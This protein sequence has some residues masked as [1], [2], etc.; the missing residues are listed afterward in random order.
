MIEE[1]ACV[2]KTLT[3]TFAQMVVLQAQRLSIDLLKY[4]QVQVN[5]LH[6]A[7]HILYPW[8]FAHVRILNHIDVVFNAPLLE[9]LRIFERFFEV[10]H[11]DLQC[12]LVNLFLSLVDA[13]SHLGSV[14]RAEVGQVGLVLG[15]H[16]VPTVLCV[17]LRS[18]LL[19]CLL[20]LYSLHRFAISF[21][22]FGLVH[23]H[24]FFEHVGKSEAGRAL[25]LLHQLT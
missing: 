24:L 2:G 16:V 20:R 3:I 25:S 4:G 14:K 21:F 23:R 7:L 10:I 5:C 12:L 18:I 9:S 8:V 17:V 22:L 19:F 1:F 6:A 15:C 11:D 13:A